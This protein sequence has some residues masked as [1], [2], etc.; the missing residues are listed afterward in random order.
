[1]SET[2]EGL[3]QV[4]E[5]SLLWENYTWIFLKNALKQA[6]LLIPFFR[7]FLEVPSYVETKSW[8][9]TEFIYK[10]K[11]KKKKALMSSRFLWDRMNPVFSTL[12]TPGGQC[13]CTG[14]EKQLVVLVVTLQR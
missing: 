9:A 7:E 8:W 1:M 12:Q 10:L 13:G 14:A 11:K 5:K 2:Y 3:Q 6:Y 4:H